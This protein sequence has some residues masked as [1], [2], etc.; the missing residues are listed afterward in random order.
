MSKQ[1]KL[2][3]VDRFSGKGLLPLYPSDIAFFLGRSIHDALPTTFSLNE[4]RLSKSVLSRLVRARNGTIV[5]VRKLSAITALALTPC[6]SI[7]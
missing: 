2:V 3:C 7:D 5:R 1:Y 4:L 6:S